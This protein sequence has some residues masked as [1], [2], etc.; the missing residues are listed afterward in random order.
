MVFSLYDTEK[1]KKE[2]K[3]LEGFC[4]ANTLIRQEYSQTG[5]PDQLE[6][7]SIYIMNK[8]LSL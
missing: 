4:T 2:N 6:H 7:V 5:K 1:E 3:F 8:K